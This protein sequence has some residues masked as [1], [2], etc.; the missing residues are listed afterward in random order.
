[1]AKMVNPNT[2]NDMTLMNAKVQIRMNIFGLKL[3][4]ISV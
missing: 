1:M 4:K 2:I 3:M